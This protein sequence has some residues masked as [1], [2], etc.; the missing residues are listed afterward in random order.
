LAELR[1][2]FLVESLADLKKNLI[3][4]GLN[5]LIRHGKPEEIL[6]SLAEAVGAYTVE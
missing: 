3:K 1:A 6:P 5:L 4:R 2:Q